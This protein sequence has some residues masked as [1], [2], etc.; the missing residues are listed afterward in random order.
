MVGRE[1]IEQ[2]IRAIFKAENATGV[3]PSAK[4][5]AIDRLM[6][7]NVQGWANGVSRGSRAE[8]RQMESVLW[9]TFPDY[10]REL[11]HL[12][13]DPPSAAFAWRITGSNEALGAIEV[14]GS[15][16]AAFD[17]QGRIERFWL[18]YD[19]PFRGAQSGS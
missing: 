9:S 11:V 16:F 1:Q 4:S 3:E 18:Y 17:D 2:T 12:V 10:H 6:T 13:I 5:D 7:P 8:E 19:D 14:H 15:S